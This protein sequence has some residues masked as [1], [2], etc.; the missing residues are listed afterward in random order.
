VDAKGCHKGRGYSRETIAFASGLR[1]PELK[2]HV[3]QRDCQHICPV[4]ALE[5][6]TLSLICSEKH[7]VLE[8]GTISFFP[9]VLIISRT[10]DKI[11]QTKLSHMYRDMWAHGEYPPKTSV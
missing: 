1:I 4:S 7:S 9:K 10:P 6:Y 3:I 2:K 5:Y 11:I 8:R